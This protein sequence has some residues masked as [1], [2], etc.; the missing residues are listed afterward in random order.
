M[1]V[2]QLQGLN[3]PRTLLYNI[4]WPCTQRMKPEVSNLLECDSVVSAWP[5][6]VKG[7]WSFRT[8][9]TAHSR[10]QHHVPDFNPRQQHCVIPKPCPVYTFPRYVVT[11]GSD[12]K[13]AHR[14]FSFCECMTVP[15]TQQLPLAPNVL[16]KH[17]YVLLYIKPIRCTSYSNYLFFHNT[18]H[19]SDGLSV[20]HQVF[21]TVNTATGICLLLYSLI[22][23]ACHLMP[24]MHL[25]L[26]LIVQPLNIHS[27]QIQQPCAF[28]EEAKVSHWGCA[29]IFWFNKEIPK[30]IPELTCQCLAAA[31]NMLH[32]LS[33]SCRICR[34]DPH[35]TSP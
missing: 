18:P 1:A 26:G 17:S 7:P 11:V 5:L 32:C 6:K 20:H 23:W 2:S 31:N 22:L 27:V 29:Y 4:M 13:Y 9:E 12:I 19:D 8:S 33:P 10:A 3:C 34:L 21:K 25:S 15:M 28:Y 35:Q 24:Q 14:C 30:N 16:C